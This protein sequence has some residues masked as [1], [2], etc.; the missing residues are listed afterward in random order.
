MKFNFT[1][2]IR[3]ENGETYTCRRLANTEEQA[4]SMVRVP[5]GETVVMIT[6]GWAKQNY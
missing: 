5:A 3:K 1:I 6:K 4:L 2:T